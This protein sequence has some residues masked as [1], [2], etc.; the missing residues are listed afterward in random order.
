MRVLLLLSLLLSLS[1]HAQ[2][3]EQVT[4]LRLHEQQASV[5]GS[6]MGGVSDDDP[7]LNPSALGELKRPFLSL[8]AVQLEPVDG[9]GLAHVLAA[10]P[11]GS[12]VVA[13][14][15]RANPAVHGTEPLLAGGSAQ[16][17]YPV[18]PDLGCAYQVVPGDMYERDERRY[19]ISAAWTSGNIT[20]GAGAEVHELDETTGI[21]IIRLFNDLTTPTDLIVMRVSGKEVV[22]NAG[23]RVRVTPKVALAAAYNGGAKFSRVVEACGLA[24]EE[25][26]C[27]TEYTNMSSVAQRTPSALRASV[28]VT[29]H[30]RLTLTGE[31]VRRNYG[32]V[33]DAEPFVFDPFRDVT[34]LH[35]GAEYRLRNV[36]LRAGWWSDPSRYG[37]AYFPDSLPIGRRLD[38]FTFGAGVDVGRARLEVAVDDADEPALR[39]AVA[40]VTFR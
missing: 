29:P 40:G 19:G 2:T 8:S 28:T 30:E 27:L 6:A 38:H 11:L 5:R 22:P 14:H 25:F 33:F 7:V 21:G 18:C 35:A 24:A 31:A 36:A 3:F 15:Y 9:N 37:N 4:L 39:R 1:L 10:V 13:A 12:F 20:L 16:R 34:E 32:E 17:P 23:I 26:R